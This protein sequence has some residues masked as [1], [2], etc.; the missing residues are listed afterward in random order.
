MKKSLLISLG[1][2]LLLSN[3]VFAGGSTMQLT[4]SLNPVAPTA[5]TGVRSEVFSF[6]VHAEPQF[7][8]T[9]KIK[10]ISV[11]CF[12]PSTISR[13][14]LLNTNG[15]ILGTASFRKDTSRLDGGTMITAK[16]KPTRIARIVA[17]DV[18]TNFKIAITPKKSAPL[19]PI[20]CGVS[21]V[22]F[23]NTATRSVISDDSVLLDSYSNFEN[24][25]A[26]QILVLQKNPAPAE[27]DFIIR[28]Q[29]K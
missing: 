3:T 4:T 17:G 7:I 1:L 14:Y 29:G 28:I 6:G 9:A 8:Q 12:T 15:K 18:S 21:H 11:S 2:S 19:Q 27:N 20:E 26:Q 13:A 25:V 5:Y 10:D 16:I 24:F 22:T 23:V